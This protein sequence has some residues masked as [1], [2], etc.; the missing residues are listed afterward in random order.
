LTQI[1]HGVDHLVSGSAEVGVEEVEYLIDSGVGQA[2]GEEAAELGQSGGG[3]P[4][5][6]DIRRRS[7]HLLGQCMVA[8]GSMLRKGIDTSD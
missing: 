4:R 8:M 7:D 1:V 3:R 5:R 6:Q 2:S